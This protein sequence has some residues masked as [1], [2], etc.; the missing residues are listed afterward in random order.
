VTSELILK[1]D[2]RKQVTESDKWN[3]NLR[4]AALPFTA[5][6]GNYYNCN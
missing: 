5:K 4:W 1:Q 3:G 2:E 6:E